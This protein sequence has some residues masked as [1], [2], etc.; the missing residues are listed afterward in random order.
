MNTFNT[1]TRALRHERDCFV[2]SFL[3]S[4]DTA[5][6]PRGSRLYITRPCSRAHVVSRCPAAPLTLCPLPLCRVDRPS[7]RAV[8][9][10]H[11]LVSSGLFSGRAFVCGKCAVHGVQPVYS[12][13]VLP[14]QPRVLHFTFAPTA[15]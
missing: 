15:N 14:R 2:D 9:T 6:I 5:P 12:P 4:A 10:C 7:P 13:A 3:H 8:T 1:F 11:L